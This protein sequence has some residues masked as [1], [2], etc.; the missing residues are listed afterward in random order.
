MKIIIKTLRKYYSFI[1]PIVILIG[2]NLL[3]RSI[4]TLA[5]SICISGLLF[6][7]LNA[8]DTFKTIKFIRDMMG[9]K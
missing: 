4:D 7:G 1:L 9:G 3:E 2:M 6:V 5:Y 8:Y